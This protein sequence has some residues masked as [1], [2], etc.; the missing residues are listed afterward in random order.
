MEGIAF[1]GL[2]LGLLRDE[3]FGVCHFGFEIFKEGAGVGPTMLE[4]RDKKYGE[5]QEQGDPE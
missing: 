1:I 2:A 3:R 4:K 5:N